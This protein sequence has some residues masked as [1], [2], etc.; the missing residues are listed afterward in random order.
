[1]VKSSPGTSAMEGKN[2]FNARL[3][4][5][6]TNKVNITLK[7][8]DNTVAWIVAH[9]TSAFVIQYAFAGTRMTPI[10]IARRVTPFLFAGSL[11]KCNFFRFLRY[12]AD[13]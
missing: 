6:R 1:M 3:I 13:L 2:F 9:T 10:I 12:H 4:M 5:V 8:M 11:F 7:K